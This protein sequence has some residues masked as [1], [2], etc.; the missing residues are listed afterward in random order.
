MLTALL[1]VLRVLELKSCQ[2]SVEQRI[3][4]EEKSKNVLE[5]KDTPRLRGCFGRHH[6]QCS[7]SSMD[8][9]QH[10]PILFLSI[11]ERESHHKMYVCV[12]EAQP[13]SSLHR[14]RKIS[15]ECECV[16]VYV[17][18]HC[19]NSNAVCQQ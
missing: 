13:R 17:S 16:C 8:V 4:V 6:L 9:C 10:E 3:Q 18:V 15:R 2:Y 19:V 5:M 1:T 7:G 14:W 12:T 11:S